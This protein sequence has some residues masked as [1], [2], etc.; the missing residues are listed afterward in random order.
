VP[1]YPVVQRISEVSILLNLHIP[2]PMSQ[3]GS[4]LVSQS[5]ADLIFIIPSL[6]DIPTTLTR[7]ALET[8]H[9]RE[10]CHYEGLTKNLTMVAPS[11]NSV[12]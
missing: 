7:K 9:S 11:V 5:Q 3:G 1:R 12:E 8:G 6:S 4:K 2:N 10:P